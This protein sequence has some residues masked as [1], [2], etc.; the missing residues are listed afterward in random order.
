MATPN[1]SDSRMERECGDALDTIDAAVFSGDIFHNK[2]NRDLFREHLE[3][4]QR[5]LV[6]I[7]KFLSEQ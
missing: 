3:R 5:E 6:E 2:E 7:E 1:V 4:W